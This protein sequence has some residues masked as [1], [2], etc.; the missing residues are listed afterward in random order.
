MKYLHMVGENSDYINN[1]MKEGNCIV[2]LGIL[3]REI[4]NYVDCQK[5]HSEGSV[6]L[7]ERTDNGKG[8]VS[9]LVL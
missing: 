7:I 3:F 2:N 8:I 4:M 5:C 9:N 6:K 1:E